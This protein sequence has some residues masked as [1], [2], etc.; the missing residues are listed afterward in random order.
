MGGA[1]P[2]V[3]EGS[4]AYVDVLRHIRL[5]EHE[6]AGEIVRREGGVEDRDRLH[7][8]RREAFC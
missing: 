3:L 4:R 7:F 6:T 2:V 1:G 5:I 8:D